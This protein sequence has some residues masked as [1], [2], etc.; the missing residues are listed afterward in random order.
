MHV[1][2]TVKPVKLVSKGLV[3]LPVKRP[4]LSLGAFLLGKTEKKSNIQCQYLLIY[5]THIEE[6]EDCLNQPS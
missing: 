3:L 5:T 6:F 1:V 2:W 4:I